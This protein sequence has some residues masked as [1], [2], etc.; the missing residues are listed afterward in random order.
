MKIERI[1]YTVVKPYEDG[2][3]N[4]AISS[5][6]YVLCCNPH[7]TED[8]ANYEV[9]TGLKQ[10]LNAGLDVLEYDIIRVEEGH[11][12]F[13]KALALHNKYE[14]PVWKQ[15]R[16]I[17]EFYTITLGKIAKWIINV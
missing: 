14:K 10:E 13:E 4:M 6:G 16:Q 9:T 7:D 17:S 8:S 15:L 11:I 12:G 3:V 1:I 5:N 2:F